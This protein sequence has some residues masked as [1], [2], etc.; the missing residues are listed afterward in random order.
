MF[1]DTGA[2]RLD[3]EFFRAEYADFDEKC[4]ALKGSFLLGRFFE[5]SPGRA[6]VAESEATYYAK[7]GVLAT[8]A[9]TGRR[10]NWQKG[11]SRRAMESHENEHLLAGSAH[12]IAYVGRQCDVVTGVQRYGSARTLDA[13]RWPDDFAASTTTGRLPMRCTMWRLSLR[14]PAGLHQVQRCGRGQRGGHIYKNDL[15]GFVRVPLPAEA[16]IA[17]GRDP[18]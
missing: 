7:H 8:S 16:W 17:V 14:R 6:L 18:S 12:E 11:R 15:G 4:K 3:A 1:R 2:Q 9:S 5:L 13:S 10:L